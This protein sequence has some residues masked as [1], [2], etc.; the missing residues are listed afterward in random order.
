[1]ENDIFTLAQN[2][3]AVAALLYS[4]YSQACVINPAYANPATFNQ[5]M[6][7][8]AASFSGHPYS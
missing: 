7:M 6:D 1:M 2:A 8:Y 4:N 3:G 5:I